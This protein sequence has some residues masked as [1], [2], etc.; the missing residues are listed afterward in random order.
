MLLPA[1]SKAKSSAR[2]TNCTSNYK[3]WNTV[4]VMYAN[5]FRDSL[6]SFGVGPSYGDWLWDVN[7]NMVRALYPYGLTVP[8]WFCPVRPDELNKATVVMNG[9]TQRVGSWQELELFLLNEGG[10]SELRMRHNDWIYRPVSE[11]D[12][13]NLQ[14]K[15]GN[16]PFQANGIKAGDPAIYGFVGKT[17]DKGASRVPILSDLLYTDNANGLNFD[18]AHA[19]NVGHFFNGKL[20]NVNLCFVDGHVSNHAA[21]QIKSQYFV[22]YFWYY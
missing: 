19:T 11:G 12:Y 18:A 3:Q 22:N 7:T 21:K 13:P 1:L 20:A 14:T 5:D 8:M 16:T 10:Y 17:S 4:C 15:A 6:P 9:K 2:V